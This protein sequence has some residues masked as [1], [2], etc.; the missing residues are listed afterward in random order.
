VL[1][2]RRRF[3]AVGGHSPALW[4]TGGE[5]AQ[6]AFDDA[7]DFSRH[8]VIG[9]AREN[10]S[11]F[12]RQPLWLDAGT[13][14]PF[15]PGDRAFVAALRAAGV[16]IRVTRSAGGHERGYWDRHWRDY[17]GWYAARLERCRGG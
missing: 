6:G 17:L 15:D 4:Q 11:A 12:A 8:D 3:C 16:R 13:S 7:A 2:S 5:T 9:T 1:H 10:P 14:D